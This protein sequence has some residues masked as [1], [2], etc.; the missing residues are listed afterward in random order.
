MVSRNDIIQQ[1]EKIVEIAAMY[2]ARNIRLFGSVA[3]NE[4]TQT[5]DVDILLTMAKGASLLDHVG[6]IQD[7]GELLK[8]RVDVVDEGDLNPRIRDRVIQEAVWL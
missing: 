1:R 4:Q 6:L 7:L 2:G 5:S 3:R 8:C